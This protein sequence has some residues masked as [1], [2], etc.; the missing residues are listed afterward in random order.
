M[1]GDKKAYKI[2]R[3]ER[4]TDDQQKCLEEN[5]RVLDQIN[6]LFIMVHIVDFILFELWLV[7]LVWCPCPFVS[8][9]NY[10]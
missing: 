10:N 3:F 9:K 5:D 1:K 7:G 6:F 2:I 4:K 8:K